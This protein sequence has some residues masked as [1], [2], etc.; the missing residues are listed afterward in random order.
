MRIDA[1]AACTL[2]TR[3]DDCETPHD[4]AEKVGF[5]DIARFLAMHEARQ[6]RAPRP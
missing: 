1:G 4:I 2:R 6:A 3:I 5:R